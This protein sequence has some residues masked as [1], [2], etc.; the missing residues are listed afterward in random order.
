MSLAALPAALVTARR[1]SLGPTSLRDSSAAA[2][3]AAFRTSGEA[4]GRALLRA[5]AAAPLVLKSWTP[6]ATSRGL[7]ATVRALE[8]TEAESPTASRMSSP[9]PVSNA[10]LTEPAASLT[11]PGRAA[12]EAIPPRAPEAILAPRGNLPP[13]SVNF[14]PTASATSA[15][16]RAPRVDWAAISPADLSSV[17]AFSESV[18]TDFSSVLAFSESVNTDLSS[19]LAFSESVPKLFSRAFRWL[20]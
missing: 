18:F 6:L 4:S 8:A 5:S 3:M 19:D 15:V 2:L 11:W 17:L 9:L 16:A 13:P 20:S 10:F 12:A 14:V 1:A 7:L